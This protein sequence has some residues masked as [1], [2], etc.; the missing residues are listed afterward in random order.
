[1]SW[2]C[3]GERSVPRTVVA[4]AASAAA[5]SS[6]RSSSCSGLGGRM[7]VPLTLDSPGSIV[8]PSTYAA[9]EGLTGLHE[10]CS[11]KGP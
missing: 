2:A 11:A 7:N 5:S 10:G 3:S 6:A 9:L 8:P 4:S 1:M